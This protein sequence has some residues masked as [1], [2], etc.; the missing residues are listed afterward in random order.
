MKPLISPRELADAIGVSESSIKRW[1]DNGVVVANKTAGGHRRI[2]ISEAV[3]FLREKRLTL[4]NPASIG[5]TDVG[6]LDSGFLPDSG[7]DSDLLFGYLKEGQAEAARGLLLSMY[8]SGRSV[9]QIVDAPL[10]DAMTRL[11]D[12]WHHD[13]SGI[14]WEH[15][16]TDIAISA[17]SRLRMIIPH[18]PESA[19]VAVGAAPAGDPYILPSLCA[20][21]VLESQGVNAVNLGP[22]T[23][24][25]SL[26]IASEAM[27]AR[28]VWLSISVLVDAE[29]LQSEISSLAADLSSDSIPIVVGGSQAATLRMPDT[30]LCHV[31][32]SMAEL[33]ALIKGLKLAAHLV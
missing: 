8:L 24:I 5:L 30:A 17:V 13:E 3:R 15:R 20:A 1:V 6:S 31:G 16:A 33:E 12:L 27:K 2:P 18:R 28:L 4:V 9:A 7:D 32:T 10:T 29:G 11:G 26:Q 21:A 19:P 22:D 23:P 14:F 25:H